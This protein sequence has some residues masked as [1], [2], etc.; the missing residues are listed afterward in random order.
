M[1]GNSILAKMAVEISANTAQFNKSLTQ[2]NQKLDAFSRNISSISKTLVAGFGI[3]EIGSGIIEVTSKF[4]KFEAVL[5]NTLG[6]SSRAQ[7]ALR[8]IEAFAQNTPFQVDEVTAA[9]VRWANQGLDPT[10]SRMGKLGDIASSLGAGFEQTA[11]AFKDLM[12]G[13][14]KRIEEVGISATQTNGKIQLSFKGVNIEIEKNAEG[15]QK[16][17]DVYS[18]L[19]GVLG[20]SDAI[21]KTLGGRISNLQDSWDLLLKTIGEANSGP[22]YATVNVLTRLTQGLSYMGLQAKISLKGLQSL[23]DIEFEKVFNFGET[24]S[25]KKI[26]DVLKEINDLN[27][28]AFFKNIENNKKKFIELLTKEGESQ[29]NVLILWDKY[30]GMRLKAANAET[31]AFI[32]KQ[33][34][35]I[36]AIKQETQAIKELTDAELIAIAAKKRLSNLEIT[37]PTVAGFDMSSLTFERPQNNSAQ[38]MATA[39]RALADA[40][41][42]ANE[43]QREQIELNE[44]QI[45]SYSRLGLAIGTTVGNAISSNESFIESIT[46]S[47]SF[48]LRANAKEI[49]SWIAKKFAI[50][51]AT[52]GYPFAIA[53]LTAGIGTVSGLLGKDWKKTSAVTPNY[54]K[55]SMGL[56]RMQGT[57]EFKIRGQ[58]LYGTLNNYNR[59]KGFLVG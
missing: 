32:A 25:L 23:S 35:T 42:A 5:T 38:S 40:I 43:K 55:A 1:P 45:D 44:K 3:Y 37:G 27:S 39:Q 47:T 59:N 24:E 30:V 22:L 52:K 9:Y 34:K 26:S 8:D 7:K 50:D 18:Q 49:A 54:S 13:Q 57:V 48:I 14:T 2:T 58:D 19:N 17:L 46:K 12:V 11:E 10:I 36:P 53:A 33:T 21:S 28:N 6:D 16:A 41:A 20:T 56:Q 51:S 4:Q 29:E 31:D 15:V